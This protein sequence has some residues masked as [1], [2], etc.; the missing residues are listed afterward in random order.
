MY[1]AKAARFPHIQKAGFFHDAAHIITL[2]HII[3]LV[4]CRRKSGI[5]FRVFAQT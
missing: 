5:L 3:M 1:V 4:I 2:T